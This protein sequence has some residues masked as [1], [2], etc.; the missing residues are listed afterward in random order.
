M[1]VLFL[2]VVAPRHSEDV[3]C[4]DYV[5]SNCLQG[6]E[7]PLGYLKP[8]FRRAFIE[9]RGIRYNPELPIA[10][11]YDFVLRLMLA[12]ASFRTFPYL[13]YFYRRHSASTLFSAVSGRTYSHAC[14]RCDQLREP[15]P[16]FSRSAGSARGAKTQHRNRSRF[17]KTRR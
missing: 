14:G 1:L 17:Y 15:S 7:S 2:K 10:E 6:R 11:D 4:V 16:D 5:R 13:T 12:G 9:A 3:S 8:L